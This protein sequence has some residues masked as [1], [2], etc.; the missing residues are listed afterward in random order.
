FQPDREHLHHICQRIGLS[1][2]ATLIFI[3]SMASICAAVGLWAAFVG[4]S[5][6]IM[7]VAFLILFACY[8]AVIS[9]I[10]RISSWF[11]KILD[12][13]ALQFTSK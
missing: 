7:F 9:Y 11:N 12:T 4:I 13:L 8:F 1:P 6:S 10:W 5:E 3:C 2:G